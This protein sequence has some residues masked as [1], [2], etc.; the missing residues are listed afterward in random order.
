LEQDEFIN[1]Y[2]LSWFRI[3]LL[4]FFKLLFIFLYNIYFYLTIIETKQ[5]LLSCKNVSWNISFYIWKAL[6][7]FR[8]EC[9]F[10]IPNMER[11]YLFKN[12]FWTKFFYLIKISCLK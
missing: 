2:D 8:I 10:L 4:F 9:F 3:L 5:Y 11:D 6:F 1:W 12:K 7:Y